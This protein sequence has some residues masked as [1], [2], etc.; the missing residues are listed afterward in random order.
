MPGHGY[1]KREKGDN[2]HNPDYRDKQNHGK[3]GQ[4]E[5]EHVV[6]FHMHPPEPGEFLIKTH[7]EQ[8]VVKKEAC[9]HD[10][11]VEA[12]NEPQVAG[13]DHQDIPE[14]VAHEVLVVSWCLKNKEDAD[15]HADSP[16]RTYDRV[17][18]LPGAP[19]THKTDHKG[20]Y[21]GGR[22]CPVQRTQPCP[23]EDRLAVSGRSQSRKHAVGDATG[24]IGNAPGNH[25]T[26]D[27][28]AGNAGEYSRQKSILKEGLLLKG[29]NKFSHDDSSPAPACRVSPFVL[30]THRVR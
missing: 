21:Q 20:G 9:G 15:G 10:H 24:N 28:P 23:T 3:S 18:P 16:D 25:I 17:L 2:H 30:R 1:W 8:L 26:A 5:Q 4:A 7:G 12:G 14:K 19:E 6:E 29:C 11:K 13:R 27:N 22:H